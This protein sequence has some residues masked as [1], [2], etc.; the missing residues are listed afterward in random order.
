[1]HTYKNIAKGTTHFQ[2]YRSKIH[3]L[4]KKFLSYIR[5]DSCK[6]II[7]K[8]DSVQIKKDQLNLSYIKMT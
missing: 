7:N 5:N 1:M 6:K 2:S 4:T 3:L 8:I